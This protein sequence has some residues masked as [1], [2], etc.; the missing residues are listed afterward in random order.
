[1][2]EGI[3]M[4]HKF[5]II[6]LTPP[7]LFD[8][9]VAIAASHAGEIGILDLQYVQ[10][11]Q[12]ARGAL[13]RLARY[14]R[15]SWGVRIDAGDDDFFSKLT[16]YLPKQTAYVIL[17][18][19]D[20]KNLVGHVKAFRDRHIA[21]LWESK[22]LDEALRGVDAGVDGLIA[23]GN[24]AG[25]W[26]GQETTFILLQRLLRN[27]S[28]PVWAQGGI[29]S[30]SAAGCYVAGAAGVVVDS[31]L[32]LTRESTIPQRA[33][34]TVAGMDGSESVCVGEEL[35]TFCRLYAP[36]GFSTVKGIRKILSDLIQR[37]S[38]DPERIKTW[39]KMIGSHLGWHHEEGCLWLLG[40]DIGLA[41]S[42]AQRF[43]TV[44][45]VLEGIRQS[46]DTDVAIASETQPFN[47]AS[48]LAQSHG[49]RYPIVQ[50]P[51]AQV[52]DR[53]SFA[54]EVAEA[55]ALPFLALSYMRA[56]DL[57]GLLGEVQQRLGN[58][59][60]GVGILGFLPSPL[61]QEQFHVFRRFR[62]PFAIIAGG[63]PDQVQPMEREGIHTYVHVPSPGL[64]K[65][66]LQA[67]TRRFIFEGR[68]CGGH[69]GP[70][71]SFVLWDAM[72]EVLLGSIPEGE[73]KDY[74]ILF[75]GGIH[76]A[77]SSSMVA[78]IGAPL[79]E[80][81]VRVGVLMGTAYLFTEEAV[82]TGALLEGFQKEALRCKETALLETGPGHTIRCTVSPY[83]EK[84]NQE[85]YR[86]LQK[87]TQPEEVRKILEEMNL[88][89]LRIA[90]KG[91]KRNPE[92]QR[93]PDASVFITLGE[94]QQRREGLYMIGQL[95]ALRDETCTM[96]GLHE[97]VSLEG[98]RRLFE[99]QDPGLSCFSTQPR[100][101]PCHIAIIGMACLMPKAS[102]LRLYWEN[103]VNK[104]N[105]ITEVPEDRWDWRL[106][107]DPDS[108]TQDKF[109]SKWG[110]FLDPVPFDPVH[111]GMPPNSLRSIEPMQL[112]TLETVGAALRDAGY[113]SRPFA[114][115]RTSIIV[116]A[117][118]GLA[119]L[120][121]SYA[122]RAALP[123]FFEDIPEEVLSRLPKWTEDS[124]PGT[125]VNVI[126][127]R[128]ANRFDFG[129]VNYSM[130][131]ACASSLAAI[132]SAVREL[133]NR[134]S[135][136]VLVAGVDTFQNPHFFFCFAKTHALSPTGRCR[137]FDKDADG[138]CISEG[139]AVVAL[140]RL[141]DAERDGDRIYGVIQGV[142]GSSDGR[143]KGLTAPHPDGQARAL[144][145]A[146][147]KSGISP[148]TVSLIEAH[149]TG[150]V[151]GDR[152]EIETL[153]RVFQSAGAVPRRCALGSVKSMI[154]HTKS[155]AGVA[156]LIKVAL[157]LHH[158]VLPPTIGV[159][160]PNPSLAESPF[161]VNTELRPW[162]HG[163][164]KYPRRAGVSSFG[165]GGTNFHV[166]VEE[167]T[168]HF[169]D[170]DQQ[171]LST[172]W[173]SELVL[174]AGS[175]RGELW[176]AIN[177]LEQGLEQGAKPQLADLAYTLW[178][179]MKGRKRLRLAIV[180]ESLDDLWKK[181][182]EVRQSLEGSGD[183]HEAR[184]IYFTER[185]LA[186]QGK[187]AFL[188][189]GQGSQ[190]PDMLRELAVHFPEIQG[191]F[192]LADRILAEQFPK[193]L[194]AYIFPPPCFSQ[195]EAHRCQEELTQT[196]V[197]QPSLSAAAIG[198]LR[199]LEALKI[200][201]DMVAG[202][203]SG[204]YAALCAGGVFKEEDLYRLTEAR[205]R[206]ILEMAGD[207]I[208]T[209]VAVKAG[210]R[211]V[212]D[213][214]NAIEQ[215]WVANLNAPTQTII[216]G[217]KRGMQ[218]AVRRLEKEGMQVRPIPVS[219]A[220]HSP[221]VAPARDRL[222]EFISTIDFSQPK[223]GVFSNTTAGLYPQDPE[224]M[225]VLLSKHL[226]SPVEFT[227]EVEHMYDT[228]ARI[229][230][231]VGPRHVLTGLTRKILGQRTHLAVA[232]D[233]RDRTGLLQLHH[234]LAQL[235]THGVPL[236][237]DR[238]YRGR[239]LRLLSLGALVKETKSQPL[240]PTTWMITGGR[241]VPLKE[242]HGGE[243]EKQSPRRVEAPS[244]RRKQE[245]GNL[246]MA[247]KTGSNHFSQAERQTPCALRGSRSSG[248]EVD[249]IMLQFQ[250]LMERFLE[251]QQEVMKAYLGGMT[252]NEGA[253]KSDFSAA[254][255]KEMTESTLEGLNQV[256]GEL[257]EGG[258]AGDD[259]REVDLQRMDARPV[260]SSEEDSD[261][262]GPA[263]IDREELTKNLVQIVSERTG[264]PEDMIDLDLD[265]DAELGI[266]SIKWVEILGKLQ[267]SYLNLSEQQAQ[268]AM[269]ELSEISTLRG[270]IEW[271]AGSSAPGKQTMEKRSG[272]VFDQQN[273]SKG[274][275]P[276]AD[277]SDAAQALPRFVLSAADT[278]LEDSHLQVGGGSV[279]VITD[280][281]RGIAQGVADELKD[282]GARV[283]L[284]GM[285]KKVKKRRRNIYTAD[286]SAPEQVDELARLV[287]RKE[288]EITGVIHL[289][290]LRVGK[291]FED[292]DL[293][294]WQMRLREEVKSL[295][296]LA[297]AVGEDL[298][299]TAKAKKAYLL[300][301]TGMGGTFGIGAEIP[302]T[303]F[304]GHG[305]LAG[306][307][308]T[309]ALEWPDVRCQV[310]DLDP[311]DS[312][313]TLAGYVLREMGSEAANVEVGCTESRR[314][315]P[316][317][318]QA[319]LDHGM[320][321]VLTMDSS[322]VV[323][324]TGGARG[325]TAE[326]AVELAK[327]YKPTILVAGRSPLPEEEPSE[328]AALASTEE[329]K[330]A[331][332]ERMRH[333]KGK[334]TPREVDDALRRIQCNREIHSNLAAMQ[335]AGA[336]VKYYQADVRDEAALGHVIQEIYQAHG[337]L[338]G[339][340]HGAGVIEDKLIEDKTADSF[341]RVFDT[342][343][344]SAFILSR[345]LQIDSLKFLVFFSSIAGR[346]GNRGQID[347]AAANEVLNKLAIYL[348]GRWPGRV[349]AINWNP[350]AK[351]GMA[352]AEALKQFAEQGIQAIEPTAGR[353]M[354][355]EEL[356][357]GRKGQAEVVIGD[358]PWNR[359]ASMESSGTHIGFPLLHGTPLKVRDDHGVEVGLTLDPSR[360]RYLQDHRID[361][362]AVFPF[363]VAMELMSE[364]VQQGWPDLVVTGIQSARR[365][366]GIVLDGGRQEI[367]VVARPQ[368]DMSAG[369][370][371]SRLDV[372][373][374]GLN[375]ER[376]PYYRATVEVGNQLPLSPDYDAAILSS[377]RPFPM[378]PDEAYE[379][380]LF[381][382]PC[383]QGI[384][385]VDGF[386][387]KGL[388]AVLLPSVPS[389]CLNR[390][391]DS[392][393]LIDPVVI[394]SAFQLSILWERA[395]YD[396][397]FLISSVGS[398]RRFGSF[399]T[400]PVRC[401]AEMRAGAGGHLL[402]T[403]FH[404]VDESGRVIAAIEN[405]EGSCS[406]ELNRIVDA[407][408]T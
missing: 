165:F 105:T 150:T 394:D 119:D 36:S 139:V 121:Q 15:N 77:L 388:C 215:V 144:K 58:R 183:I 389:V 209:M 19:T 407:A 332:I 133:E 161:Y 25:G 402:S 111:Y 363:A 168:G 289:L 290:P 160:N 60:W 193:P 32:L 315:V 68:E 82:S 76:D 336:R 325:I 385:K 175:S 354:L 244:V 116:G 343:V 214:I 210:R 364:V 97:K 288:G 279:F 352:T 374:G 319:P 263:G 258:R 361:G 259:V 386:N 143:H 85:K 355:D 29:G 126:A 66:F 285:G 72:T 304:A 142:E 107:F 248:S 102:E 211:E 46:I 8:P 401:W 347:Y 234:V 224:E 99:L 272:D 156:G 195:E 124:F 398:Y 307:V 1:V 108:D 362:K 329:L 49:T 128:V 51:M 299:R 378:S 314:L 18:G 50:G 241:A 298:R 106:Y 373:I 357:Y 338:D 243:R 149:G 309:L 292:M 295:F 23:K 273:T 240:S 78:A 323:L 399:S 140:K 383:F 123:M 253:L 317:L 221:V 201:P 237:L 191:C 14:A 194:S 246:T 300:T 230:I 359:A 158:K 403:D 86:L 164:E 199:L 115:E 382:G 4:M 312:I 257:E 112:L 163:V 7:G 316:V 192:N 296:Y 232:V 366:Q 57:E 65:M 349:V 339:L 153:K 127:G 255:L 146:Y 271:F 333:A 261:R 62:P 20:P 37:D 318:K 101:T 17:T 390:K 226:V 73:F 356:G 203:S 88:G 377:L 267:E 393:W 157:A 54:A 368:S 365:F 28:L 41:K 95:A 282:L 56:G 269:E 13:D 6:A 372:T 223:I 71:S 219:C 252:E 80:K 284:V 136:M 396:M 184:G 33:K 180:A 100:E 10:E 405:M 346:F 408:G 151:A 185:P 268:A 251:T 208:G 189:P 216:S 406:K 166:V 179:N 381:H 291:R 182:K 264:Y 9:A 21:V 27:T 145:R 344:D 87:E 392:P 233:K 120:G 114:R 137:T 229:F 171:A 212:E 113:A 141:A 287:R 311:T 109:Y 254:S 283:A 308:K 337:R 242:A 202:H 286:L 197:A 236:E 190:H 2:L 301:A 235:A 24:E 196:N 342:K 353:R 173:P 42:F 206:F 250:H 204:E 188:F 367:R 22:S 59:P 331:L 132:H 75:A 5:R 70:R 69:V 395:H 218:E 397:T 384:S 245:A 162:V 90:S 348:D 138:T 79:V 276:R 38:S 387:D 110:G 306:I 53:A 93:S 321:G 274:G 159:E 360:D 47:E 293:K 328:T 147:A 129:G 31:Q 30:H 249:R 94:E 134:T 74:H 92:H 391:I 83:A 370:E 375:Q 205:G 98:S 324:A 200:R 198:I 280:D 327:R 104:V 169:L 222:A 16:D 96:E 135:D 152:S 404:F 270:V 55:G 61:R 117:S 340:I 154:G 281:E 302:R 358:G 225:R 170:S 262:T 178:E 177:S 369:Q 40:Q 103:I 247:K 303:A 11:E 335:E 187:M 380:W 172:H 148:A 39:K 345:Q 118:G 227:R 350:W 48:P 256:R 341:D 3:D 207:D 371:I 238:L 275:A 43:L 231:E 266:D 12:I 220:F 81:G 334:P 320:A 310:V 213:I 125:L 64:L 265:M 239:G 376:L 130:D 167:Y 400:E 186:S 63:R 297:K 305:A 277:R 379:K 131:A 44:G 176:G 89:R 313:S 52:S 67:G 26:V 34:A 351:A 174:F 45:G 294:Q 228:G 330:A 260:E 326:A 155:A 35:G 84:F 322:W 217:T 122:F 91:V 181:L 278:P